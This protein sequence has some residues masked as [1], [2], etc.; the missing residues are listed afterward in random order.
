MKKINYLI[1][2]EILIVIVVLCTNFIFNRIGFIK[3]EKQ[4]QKEMSLTSK[5]VELNNQLT[6]ANTSTNYANYVQTCKSQ[7]ATALTNERVTTSFDSTL[8]IIAENISKVLQARTKDA[9]ATADNI[10]EGKTAWVNGELITGTGADNTANYEKGCLEGKKVVKI[11]TFNEDA[12]IAGTTVNQTV[13]VSSYEGYQNFDTSNF[14]LDSIAVFCGNTN[15]NMN[16]AWV[17]VSYQKSYNTST[18]VFTITT[19]ES[20]GEKTRGF[21]GNVYLIY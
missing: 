18:G 2:F 3:K 11:K 8:E 1:I 14:L 13:N 6:E 20:H 15:N 5:E 17:G 4:I 10:T 19:T 12:S 7:L 9:T 21:I 16:R